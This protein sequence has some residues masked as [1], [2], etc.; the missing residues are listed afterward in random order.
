MYGYAIMN[1]MNLFARLSMY[2]ANFVIQVIQLTGQQQG[3]NEDFLS[4]ILDKWM[5]KVSHWKSLQVTDFMI[6]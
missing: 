3:M 2:D 4:N 1:Y 6:V 5:D